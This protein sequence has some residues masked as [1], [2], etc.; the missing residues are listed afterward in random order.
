MKTVK[1]VSKKESK[2]NEVNVTKNMKVVEAAK[3]PVSKPY[4]AEEVTASEEET[5]KIVKVDVKNFKALE[6]FTKEKEE[7]KVITKK[8]KAEKTDTLHRQDS[9]ITAIREL[10]VKGAN[11]KEIMNRANEIHIAA[12]GESNP[13]ATNVNRYSIAALV[14]FDILT[15][16][17][18]GVYTLK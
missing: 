18:K 14:A 13:T 10:C 2:N 1:E 8:E 12:G 6:K 7:R 4:I 11:M 15:V 5:E 3:K 16:N 17:E 9:V